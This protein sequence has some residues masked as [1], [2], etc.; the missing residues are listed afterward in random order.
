MENKK[1]TWNKIDSFKGNFSSP[2]NSFHRTCPV[3][4]CIDYKKVFE[5]SDFQFFTD[6]DTIPKRINIVENVCNQCFALFLNPC[7]S[8]FGFG[9]LFAEAGRSYGQT[10]A[11][12][13]E[14]IDWMKERGLLKDGTSLF[15]AGCYEGDF[16]AR[17][18][19]KTKKI[20]LDIDEPAII[21]GKE[22]HKEHN[23]SFVLG[24]FENFEYTGTKPDVITMFHVL[25]HL[26]RPVQA[27]KKLRSISHSKTHLII[28]VPILENGLTNDIN[29]FF[30]IQHM[31]HFSRTS[32]KNC[33]AKAG[34][35][36]KE[37]YEHAD[38]NGCRVLAQPSAPTNAKEVKGDAGDYAKLLN[39]LSDW[40]K[41]ASAVESVIQKI[42]NVE[43]LI[44][45]GGG[46]H[47]EFLYQATSLFSAERSREY[48][49]IDSDPMKQGKTWRGIEITS[50]SAFDF[51]NV[52]DV[53]ILI[54]SYGSQNDILKILLGMGVNRKNIITLYDKV[55][56]Y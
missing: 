10:E 28:E 26:P 23:I 11:R 52:K 42:K 45:W 15:D 1:I 30:S 46:A 14:Q 4:E 31:T 49:V 55:R 5:H 33:I 54:S 39:Y 48:V 40:Y 3:C 8:T 6:S 19:K 38:Y 47:I 37:I 35:D 44:I 9:S 16:L 34:W 7:Y 22:R 32:L 50:S 29:G 43:K 53:K 25:E 27:L 24:D 20:G 21:R 51:R 41:S 2:L 12:P 18:P 56:V 36:I 17:L 13:F